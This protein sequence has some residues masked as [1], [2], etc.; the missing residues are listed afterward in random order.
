[1]NDTHFNPMDT[2]STQHIVM[3]IY[4]TKNPGMDGWNGEAAAWAAD[5][6]GKPFGIDIAVNNETDYPRCHVVQFLYCMSK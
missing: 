5:E 2:L 4:R 6:N 3:F 1:M